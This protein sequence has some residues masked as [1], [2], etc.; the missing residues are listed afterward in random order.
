MIDA[1]ASTLEIAFKAYAVCAIAAVL[2]YAIYWALRRALRRGHRQQPPPMSFFDV[3]RT[4]RR[5][6]PRRL[7]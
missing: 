4:D 7:E 5:D 2:G 3:I 6:W 1:T